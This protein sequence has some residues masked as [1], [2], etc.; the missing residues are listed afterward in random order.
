M[1]DPC[2]IFQKGKVYVSQR[3]WTSD[4]RELLIKLLAKELSRFP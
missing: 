4:L 2:V 3:E 1:H